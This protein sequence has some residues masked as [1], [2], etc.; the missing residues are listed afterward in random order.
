MHVWLNNLAT[1]GSSHFCQVAV[2]INAP[3][4]FVE[5]FAQR[6]AAFLGEQASQL[7][8]MFTQTRSTGV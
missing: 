3:L 2:G 6:L 7:R 5:R 4:D 1:L 8:S